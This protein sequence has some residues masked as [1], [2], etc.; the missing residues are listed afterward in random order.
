[1]E[2]IID[3][4]LAVIVIAVITGIGAFF[5]MYFGAKIA[6]KEIKKALGNLS[7]VAN[8]EVKNLVLNPTIRE[9]ETNLKTNS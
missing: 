9:N 8:I 7:F 6:S 5:G 1:M 2:T 3:Q 4:F